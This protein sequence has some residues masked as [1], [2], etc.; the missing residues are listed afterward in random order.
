MK[1]KIFLVVIAMISIVMLFV[2]Y[3]VIKQ[4][5]YNTNEKSLT[6]KAKSKDGSIV[7]YSVERK[8]FKSVSVKLKGEDNVKKVEWKS[9]DENWN[10]IT[11]KDKSNYTITPG[12]GRY[13]CAIRVIGLN[14]E[15]A[16]LEGPTIESVKRINTRDDSVIIKLVAKD[17]AGKG[18]IAVYY[19]DDNN[20]RIPKLNNTSIDPQK[21]VIIRTNERFS[22]YASMAKKVIV[23]SE[24][25]MSNVKYIDN[26][27]ISDL[28]FKIDKI[29]KKT[30]NIDDLDIS[31]YIN[32]NFTMPEDITLKMV[33]IHMSDGSIV[34]KNKEDILVQSVNDSQD[35][36]MISNLEYSLD[37]TNEI[38]PKTVELIGEYDYVIGKELTA[39]YDMLQIDNIFT[40]DDNIIIEVKD[41]EEVE[42]LTY[43]YNDKSEFLEDINSEKIV[44][45]KKDELKRFVLKGKA[46][47]IIDYY[48]P[49]ISI[50]KKVDSDG[51]RFIVEA[52]EFANGISNDN[53]TAINIYDEDDN[54]IKLK[55]SL[56]SKATKSEKN[57]SLDVKIDDE[58]RKA[59]T[60]RVFSKNGMVGERKIDDI[61]AFGN[62]IQIKEVTNVDSYG[63]RI[64][65][66]DTFYENKIEK[67]KMQKVDG[68]EDII[69]HTNQ[70]D[71][72]ADIEIEPNLGYNKIAV[73]NSEGEASDWYELLQIKEIKSISTGC[74]VNINKSVFPLS[75][76][77]W[78]Y[79]DGNFKTKEISGNGPISADIE[80]KDNKKESIMMIH[81]T[82][83]L[84]TNVEYQAP[85]II[86]AEK[87]ED[88]GG[89]VNINIDKVKGD[90]V[91]KVILYD[92]DGKVLKEYNSKISKEIAN[93]ASLSSFKLSYK[94]DD[95]IRACKTV[96]VVSESGLSRV[97]DIRQIDPDISSIEVQKDKRIK[98]IIKR[99]YENG[100][101]KIEWKRV[102]ENKFSSINLDKDSSA[103]IPKNSNIEKIRISYDNKTLEYGVVIERADK[104]LVD[105][106]GLWN[107]IK[108]IGGWNKKGELT[109]KASN[110]IGDAF[111]RIEI[112]VDNDWI[113][114]KSLGKNTIEINNQIFDITKN[115]IGAT[116]VRVYTKKGFVA[117]RSIKIL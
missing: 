54:I 60:V 25:G 13:I 57:I 12:E 30:S 56:L 86:K 103:Y 64:E 28:T 50:A 94:L 88:G 82:D 47:S 38:I 69:T 26:R 66:K 67:V 58:I 98:V 37:K 93:S 92:R 110:N 102:G 87:V 97:G 114:L 2:G 10:V 107:A 43:Y 78:Y 74:R 9:D 29:D 31:K 65:I 14:G 19:Y 59:V 21:E 49:N 62:R 11:S 75:K 33:K 68:T 95:A 100:I 3:K 5:V 51:G 35:K 41:K 42:S 40:S 24:N 112:Y 96:K 45:N 108:S 105:G 104:L 85:S 61:T 72:I 80:G 101:K 76:I 63:M 17:E 16:L 73:I 71:K 79:Q 53:I 48:G 111:D 70:T 106:K 8:D 6:Y 22:E 15:Q 81:V 39:S 18:I 91:D 23:F 7:I 109:I 4:K 90:K 113:K 117:E 83:V 116:K 36:K 84:G 52:S 46:K 20:I 44:I 32:I 99:A 34:E 55:D 27:E 77:T 115:K 1:R 89:K